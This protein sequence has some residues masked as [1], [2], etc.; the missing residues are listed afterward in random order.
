MSKSRGNYVDPGE[1]LKV[2]GA[3]A[4][5]WY[6]YIADPVGTERRFSL[7]LV[8][9]MARKFLS[10]LWNT[11]V[12]FVTYALIDGYDPRLPSMPV[13]QRP[14]LDRWILSELN[15]LVERVDE[16]LAGFEATRAARSLQEFVEY[17][18]NW[19]VRRSRR[20]FWKSE[21][22]EDKEAAYA[23]LYQ[24]LTTLS[25]LLAPFIP[26]LAEEIYRNLV[27][28]VDGQAPESVHLSEF[29]Q[30]DGSLI[31]RELMA[32]TR[33]VM[34]LVSLGHAARNAAG[35]KVR[36]PLAQVLVKVQK[37]EE[38]EVLEALAEQILEELNVK[39][40]AFAQEE[41]LVEYEVRP[42]PASLG[43]K[44]GPL[45]PRIKEAL[46]KME[47][48][49]VAQRVRRGEGVEVVVEERP[50][51]LLPEEL[52]VVANPREG[53]SVAEEGGYVVAIT[54]ALS[55]EL[56]REGLAREVVRRIQILRKEADFRIED[57]IITYFQADPFLCEVIREWEGYIKRETLSLALSE[58]EGSAGSIGESYNLDGHPLALAVERT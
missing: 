48:Q 12:F 56:I 27:C 37:P 21:K 24:C 16:A 11:Y 42:L 34:R 18:S 57:N 54:T 13:A 1:V 8:G 45:F 22:D 3:D 30:P 2:H 47:A 44:Y 40:L 33:L 32:D 52:E 29:P 15:L 26:F 51:Q 7:D 6:F 20:R 50:L 53:L 43:P 4:L 46:T 23:T 17:L 9:E 5:R 19:Y 31:D 28:L 36:Q 41:E 39:A 35:L 38:K 58:G 49:A 55:D 25:R 14:P 10:T